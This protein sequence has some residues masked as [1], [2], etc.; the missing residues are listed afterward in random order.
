MS[1][2]YRAYIAKI[3]DLRQVVNNTLGFIDLRYR[4][5][6]FSF[7]YESICLIDNG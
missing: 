4:S 3:H 5:N 1:A 7:D 6:L 2:E